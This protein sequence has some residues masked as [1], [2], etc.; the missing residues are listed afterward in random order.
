MFC[1]ILEPFGTYETLPY[2]TRTI[3]DLGTLPTI[4]ET[5]LEPFSLILHFIVSCLNFFREQFLNKYLLCK[6]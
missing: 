3:L 5:F 2:V 4:F 6:D 1:N